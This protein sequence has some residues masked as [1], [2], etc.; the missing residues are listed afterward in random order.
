MESKKKR[1]SAR[2]IR[3]KLRNRIQQT[4]NKGKSTQIGRIGSMVGEQ[5]ISPDGDK[6]TSGRCTPLSRPRHPGIEPLSCRRRE[7][8]QSCGVGQERSSKEITRTV[9]SCA[10]YVPIACCCCCQAWRSAVGTQ[11]CFVLPRF[12]SLW[13]SRSASFG[14][15]QSL[16]SSL[17]TARGAC[18][19]HAP[20]SSEAARASECTRVGVGAKPR[21]C[22]L[23]IL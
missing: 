18:R 10:L 23:D 3:E 11:Q 14:A 16:S 2:E 17:A 22:R 5:C 15:S 20:R 19:V 4:K 7:R 8:W 21:G 13:R 12:V 6:R 9:Q 1:K